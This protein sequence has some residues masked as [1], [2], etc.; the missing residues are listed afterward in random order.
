MTLNK[1]V[2]LRVASQISPELLPF[3]DCP[4]HE[5]ATYG[6][7][8]KDCHDIVLRLGIGKPQIIDS[9]VARPTMLVP[10]VLP[11]VCVSL[12]IAGPIFQHGSAE[13]R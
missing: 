3:I 10:L 7:W 9:C 12:S 6:S 8:E 11:E 5:Q 1:H 4:H 13:I 2:A